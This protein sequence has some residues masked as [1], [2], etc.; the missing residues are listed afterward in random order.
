MAVETQAEEKK[1][2]AYSAP[3][4]QIYGSIEAL[5]KANTHAG[6]A[7]DHR[8]GSADVRTTGP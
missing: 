6:V 8:G 1:R 3:T 5:T 4:L 7:N 2:K